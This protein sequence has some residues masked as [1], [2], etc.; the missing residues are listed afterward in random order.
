MVAVAGAGAGVSSDTWI[1]SALACRNS[2]S[3]V[4]VGVDSPLGTTEGRLR[5]N[6]LVYL[7]RSE[8]RNVVMRLSADSVE[9]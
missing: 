5:L 1:A 4:R 8:R 6:W 9:K 2:T 7:T 3:F